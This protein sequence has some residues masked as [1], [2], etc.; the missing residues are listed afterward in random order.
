MDADQH[1]ASHQISATAQQSRTPFA[2]LDKHQVKERARSL[3]A[4]VKKEKRR[5]DEAEAQAAAVSA[6]LQHTEA[7]LATAMASLAVASADQ[8]FVSAGLPPLLQNLAKAIQ[9]GHLRPAMFLAE[10]L[11]DVAINLCK[12]HT[13]SFSY[14]ENVSSSAICRRQAT[15]K[16]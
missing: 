8:V 7:Q 6:K 16:Q 14:S 9:L 11:T 3:A 2:L 10:Y 13:T 12:Q 5:A 4:S 1:V 15:D